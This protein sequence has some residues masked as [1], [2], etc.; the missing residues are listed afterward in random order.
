MFA[1]KVKLAKKSRNIRNIVISLIIGVTVG[2]TI[3]HT[4]LN[5]LVSP[6]VQT[7]H[8]TK[9]EISIPSKIIQED[10]Q[11]ILMPSS[12]IDTCF[13]PPSGCS[14]V[15]TA[16]IDKASSSIY[17]QAYGFTDVDIADSLIAAHKR[18]VKVKILLDKSNLYSKYSKLAKIKS[19]GIDVLIDNV[20]GI[21]H[22]KVMIID[23]YTVITGSFNFSKNADYKNAE[24]IIIINDPIVSGQYL[25]NW[26]SREH[27]NNNLT[28]QD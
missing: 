24:N 12:K 9:N 18:G 10:A 7:A 22:N 8:S 16:I 4:I 3:D 15:I 13:T 20:P 1:N 27:V 26:L 14:K 25:Q 19:A 2:I 5:L 21:A 6:D 23:E 11:A 28:N 17:V